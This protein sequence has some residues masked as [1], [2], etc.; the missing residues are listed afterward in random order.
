M[1][2][3]ACPSLFDIGSGEH[4]IWLSLA[5]DD[6]RKLVEMSATRGCKKDACHRAISLAHSSKVNCPGVFV[7]LRD[8]ALAS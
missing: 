1:F 3:T 6:Q 8:C 2:E 7:P 5:C 4:T